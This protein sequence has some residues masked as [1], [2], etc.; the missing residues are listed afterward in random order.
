MKKAFSANENRVLTEVYRRLKQLHSGN[1]DARLL[2]L[3]LPSEVKTLVKN[4]YLKP[5]S[6]ETPRVINWYNLTEKGKTIFKY[7]DV[8]TRLSD[9]EDLELF[10]NPNSYKEFKKPI[11]E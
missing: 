3:L 2:I 6:S 8:K 11:E 7:H 1:L 9:S 5:H 4:G 10:S